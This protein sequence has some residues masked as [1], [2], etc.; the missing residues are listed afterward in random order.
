[1]NAYWHSEWRARLLYPGTMAALLVMLAALVLVSVL[2]RIRA[3]YA[4][5]LRVTKALQDWNPPFASRMMRALTALSNPLTLLAMGAAVMLFGL[6][7]RAIVPALYASATIGAAPLNLAFKRLFD[8]ERPGERDVR[9]DL[10]GRRWGFSYPSGHA[11]TSAA[12]FGF[13]AFLVWIYTRNPLV[14]DP[15]VVL[16][17]LLPIGVG[18]SRIYLGAHWLSDVVGGWAFGFAITVLAAILYPL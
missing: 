2:V 6:L 16:L 13:L 5:D 3:T 11:M 14:R 12:F 15:L 10:R 7:T 9:V 4:F 1:M 17:S 18:I 8:R